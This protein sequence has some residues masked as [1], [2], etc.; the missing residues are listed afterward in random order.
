[1]KRI[2]RIALAIDLVKIGNQHIPDEEVVKKV[3]EE[4]DIKC[5]EEDLRT[6]YAS[7]YADNFEAESEIIKHYGNEIYH[8]ID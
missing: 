2:D 6:V 3:F 4:F 8:E 7:Y 1:M 5:T